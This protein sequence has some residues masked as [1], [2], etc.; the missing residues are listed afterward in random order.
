MF[1]IL[2]QFIIQHQTAILQRCPQDGGTTTVCN[3]LVEPTTRLLNQHSR[4]IVTYV[5]SLRLYRLLLIFMYVYWVT[6]KMCGLHVRRYSPGDWLHAL[7]AGGPNALPLGG[8]SIFKQV[9]LIPVIT[10][11]AHP[12]V[13]SRWP[14]RACC[15]SVTLVCPCCCTAVDA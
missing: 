1:T 11:M 5:L 7:G 2:W 9:A 4:H 15:L 3:T 10:F 6:S 8:G 14:H 12:A 13:G